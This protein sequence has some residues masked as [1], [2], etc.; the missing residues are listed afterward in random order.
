MG[1]KNPPPASFGAVSA[2]VNI[3]DWKLEGAGRSFQSDVYS[4][5]LL[6]SA[7]PFSLKISLLDKKTSGFPLKALFA[8]AIKKK[9]NS[10]NC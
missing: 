5:R 7:D 10:N 2:S 8:P 3:L 6:L 1:W 4:S 9:K